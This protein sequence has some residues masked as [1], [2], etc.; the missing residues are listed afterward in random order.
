MCAAVDAHGCRIGFFQCNRAVLD[1]HVLASVEGSS[2]AL[3][4]EGVPPL[5]LGGGGYIRCALL[6]VDS[7]ECDVIGSCNHDDPVIG[8]GGSDPRRDQRVCPGAALLE[9]DRAAG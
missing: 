7:V 4:H 3:F 8:R 2:I 5:H 6:H 9:N 1:G